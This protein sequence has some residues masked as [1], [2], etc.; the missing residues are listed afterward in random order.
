MADALSVDNG[1]HVFADS[2]IDSDNAG[3]EEEIHVD[4]LS[5]LLEDELLHVQ[6]KED[7]GQSE[8]SYTYSDEHLPFLSA[9][10]ANAR[11]RTWG[12]GRSSGRRHAGRRAGGEPASG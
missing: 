12:R 4:D 8:P 5:L 2:N 9:G 7:E 11:G 10:A 1:S 3:V 6:Q